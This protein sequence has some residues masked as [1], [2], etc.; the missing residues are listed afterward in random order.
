MADEESQKYTVQGLLTT[1]RIT[2]E[3]YIEH[4]GLTMVLPPTLGN[5]KKNSTTLYCELC[6]A[7]VQNGT[8]KLETV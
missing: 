6:T 1:A 2:V 8:K 4:D 5:S 7:T 3:L